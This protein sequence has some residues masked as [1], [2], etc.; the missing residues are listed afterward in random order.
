MY[1]CEPSF[2]GLLLGGGLSAVEAGGD[3]AVLFLA[4]VAAPGGFA[5]AR[6]RAAAAAYAFGVG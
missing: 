5:F 4:F 2:P 6:G 3:F 1:V